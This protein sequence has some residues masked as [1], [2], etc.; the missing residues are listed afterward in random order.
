MMYNTENILC[1][2]L[3]LFNNFEQV[4]KMI[5]DRN[6]TN[7]DP[8]IIWDSK[9]NGRLKIWIDSKTYNLLFWTERGD[10]KGALCMNSQYL[11]QINNMKSV[12]YDKRVKAQAVFDNV[13]DNKNTENL[14]PSEFNQ[15]ILDI[16]LD[17]IS[18]KGIDSLSKM[19]KDFL[20]SYT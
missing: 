15:K 5:K 4:E 17:K 20:S 8:Y 1:F 13:N 3:N 19:E 9:Q 7:L 10:K 18:N 6:L 11:Q 2:H 12:V 14:Q 16:I